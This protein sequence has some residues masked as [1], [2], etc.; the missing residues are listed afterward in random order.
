MSAT[1][2]GKDE[3]LVISNKSDVMAFVYDDENKCLKQIDICDKDDNPIASIG[4]INEP[5][6]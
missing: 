2:I 5:P 1:V 6:R 3:V 4:V